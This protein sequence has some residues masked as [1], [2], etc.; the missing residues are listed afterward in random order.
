[1][2]TPEVASRMNHSDRNIKVSVCV[3]TYNQEPYVAHCLQSLI[4]QQTSFDVEIIV[5]DDCSKDGTQAVIQRFVDAYPDRIR[6]ILQPVNV[7]ANANYLAVHDA[8][9][10]EYIAHMDGD[11]YA[12]PGKLQMQAD[13]LDSHPECKVVWHAVEYVEP[14][15]QKRPSRQVA[16]IGKHFWLDQGD[17]IN[18]LVIGTHSAKMYRKSVRDFTPPPGGFTDFILGVTQ[19]ETGSGVMVC[20]REYGGYRLGIGMSSSGWFSR[21][22]L[23]GNLEGL[24]AS[25]PQHRAQIFSGTLHLLLSDIKRRNPTLGQ[26]LRVIRK[27]FC[28]SGIALYLRSFSQRS[29]L[30]F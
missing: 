30:K 11:D 28:L 18:Y 5:A 17:H 29:A 10:G 22:V 13:L 24:L 4:D 27:A 25:H 2:V 9:Q 6:A 21:R 23:L 12:L 7:G 14:G 3:V 20:D 15:G 8:A 26:S 19:L 1:M 16:L